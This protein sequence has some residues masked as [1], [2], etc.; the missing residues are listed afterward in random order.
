MGDDR[1]NYII[2]LRGKQ[3]LTLRV[4]AY[5]LEDAFKKAGVRPS[6]RDLII[7]DCGTKYKFDGLNFE[8][9]S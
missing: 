8:V 3:K 6:K 7:N 9:F 1:R 2:Y 5:G 4:R